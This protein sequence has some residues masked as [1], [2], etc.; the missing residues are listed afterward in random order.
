MLADAA[1]IARPL[2]TRIWSWLMR[3]GIQHRRY[4]DTLD[5]DP[6]N[7]TL[8]ASRGHR[9]HDHA[10]IQSEYYSRHNNTT[11]ANDMSMHGYA[12]SCSHSYRRNMLLIA[13]TRLPDMLSRLPLTMYVCVGSRWVF[14]CSPMDYNP[15]CCPFE[16]LSS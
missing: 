4:Y 15:K 1:Y 5:G 12:L 13:N 11:H 16:S 9:V 6:S 14:G 10:Q 2:W 7:R 8:Q 3:I